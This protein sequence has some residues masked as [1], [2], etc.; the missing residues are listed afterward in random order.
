MRSEADG[1]RRAVA[2][3]AVALACLILVVS[4][5]VPA[6]VAARPA[7]EVPVESVS[8]DGNPERPSGEAWDTVPAADVPL[9]SAPSGL[10]NASD[11][12]VETV[13]VQS[14]RTDD[15]FYVR[16]SWADG[17]ADRN[18]TGP[19]R[20]VDAAAVQ[21]PADASTRPPIA[22]GG[23]RNMVNVWYW[24]ADGDGEEL[25]AGGAGTTTEIEEGGVNA[26]ATHDDGRWTVVMSRDLESNAE[27]RTSLAVD[28]DVD[29]AFAVWNGSGME[30]SGRKAVSEWHHVPLGGGPQ[31]P[32]YETILWTVAGLAIAGVALVTVHAVRST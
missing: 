28:H 2:V 24:R 9:A 21:V 6:L 22:M 12:S 3:G 14:A 15:R 20:F 11:T 10:P 30:R 32:P 19:R 1:D 29:V 7:Y 23:T 26:T 8:A 16:L 27:N 13:R 5:L 17:T 18:V 25:L 4:A 31:G